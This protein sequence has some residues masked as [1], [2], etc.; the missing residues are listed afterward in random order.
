MTD[1][2]VENKYDTR[3]S[4]NPVYFT[5]VDL[6]IEACLLNGYKTSFSIEIDQ[7]A[8]SSVFVSLLTE[9]KALGIASRL[10][11][12]KV[13]YNKFLR[14]A[15]EEFIKDEAKNNPDNIPYS[16]PVRKFLTDHKN[17]LKLASMCYFYSQGVKG[18][19][20]GLI[21][22]SSDL[23]ILWDVDC[24]KQLFRFSANFEKIIERS[25]PGLPKQMNRLR[26][27]NKRMLK[28]TNNG[29]TSLVTVNNSVIK[30]KHNS[31]TQISKN[32]YDVTAG[33]SV[34]FSYNIKRDEANLQKSNDSLLAN[35]MHSLD[36][37]LIHEVTLNIFDKN[38]FTVS[39]LHDS[40]QV[41]PNYLQET[42]D[43]L[44]SIYNSPL[45]RN[46]A[47][48][49]FKTPWIN[50]FPPDHFDDPEEDIK[51]ILDLFNDFEK[52]KDISFFSNINKLKPNEMYPL[53]D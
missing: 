37:A 10:F 14:T 26:K 39:H 30:Y 28:L 53:E 45:F 42:Y 52:S 11:G 51:K 44:Y 7:K 9:N 13:D 47:T 16:K 21:S 50:S 40:L 43:E 24:Q 29:I 20:E 8:S 31:Y 41:H 1:F 49:I 5:L 12:D 18:R 2:F 19:F 27:I 23:N 34:A 15:A 17:P 25:F 4:G 38:G 32:R 3:L 35:I 33:K 36:S 46:L 6:E 22:S 48:R